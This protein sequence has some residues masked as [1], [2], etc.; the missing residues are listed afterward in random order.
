MGLPLDTAKKWLAARRG[1][2]E[3]RDRAFI[4]ASVRA[5]HAA[6]RTWRGVQAVVCVL[7]LGIIASLLVVVYK[8][9]I[10]GV[11]FEYFTVR[12][13]MQANVRPHTKDEPKAD[14]QDCIAEGKD[15][16]PK[17]II[18]RAGWFMMGSQ[19]T[20]KD[21]NLDETPQ[22][23]VKIKRFAV[24][25]FEVTFEE[26]D[27]CVTYGDCVRA[28]DSGFERGQQPVINV[29]FDDAKRYVAWLSRMTGKDYRLLSEAEYEYA[30]R[31]GKKTVYPWGDDIGDG[32]AN[33]NGCGSSWLKHPTP[34]SFFS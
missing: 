15:Y 19:S 14:F 21:S 9:E 31:G 33:C 25:K 22:H 3:P 23:E 32:N 8:D 27:T 12:P 16:C 26:W 4:E 13:F 11:R 28:D 7:L 1:D 17:M 24:S 10:N 20:A 6:A 5:E 2:I 30:A 18:V 29:S 34:V